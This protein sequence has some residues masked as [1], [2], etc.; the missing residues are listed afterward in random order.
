MSIDFF[1]YETEAVRKYAELINS[2]EDSSANT[3]ISR[4]IVAHMH[5]HRPYVILCCLLF[6]LLL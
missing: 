2:Q 5:I 1:L 3:M 6:C 4:V